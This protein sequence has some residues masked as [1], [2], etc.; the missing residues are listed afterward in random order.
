MAT[1]CVTT[2]LAVSLT[3]CLPTMPAGATGGEG[4]ASSVAGVVA[5]TAKATPTLS[6]TTSGNASYEGRTAVTFGA[7]VKAGSLAAAGHLR[8]MEG[9]VELGSVKLV[10]GVGVFTLPRDLPVGKHR[11]TLVFEPSEGTEDKVDAGAWGYTVTVKKTSASRAKTLDGKYCKAV[12]R[13]AK[14]KVTSIQGGSGP[15]KSEYRAYTKAAAADP[16]AKGE[17]YWKFLRDV[18]SG[19]RLG[20]VAT[21]SDAYLKYRDFKPSKAR[22]HETKAITKCVG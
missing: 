7:T 8:F 12:Q 9:D 20:K 18:G 6:G 14:A 11:L 13:V 17:R 10:D 1:L 16:S 2:L 22:Q 5:P 4:P 3:L 19:V 15:D 21:T